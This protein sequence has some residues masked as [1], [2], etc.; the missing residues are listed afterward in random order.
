M[1]HST[2]RLY[3]CVLTQLILLC[4]TVALRFFLWMLLLWS[5]TTAVMSSTVSVTGL[6]PTVLEPQ[7]RDFLAYCGEIASLHLQAGS[8]TVTFTSAEGAQTAELLSG[9]VLGTSPVTIVAKAS[10]PSNIDSASAVAFIESMVSKGIVTGESVVAA[11]RTRA[12]AVGGGNVIDVVHGGARVVV[13]AGQSAAA[14]VLG[15]K[16]KGQPTSGQWMYGNQPQWGAP[17]S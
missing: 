6:C 9:A 4:E 10:G 15:T 5:C 8:A 3:S 7:L 17:P 1:L 16:P 2:A 11:L 14:T 12:A 13:G